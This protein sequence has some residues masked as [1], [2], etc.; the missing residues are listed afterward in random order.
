[1]PKKKTWN[2]GWPCVNVISVADHPLYAKKPLLW[3]KMK[4]K[5][6]WPLNAMHR[7]KF[8]HRGAFTISKLLQTSIYLFWLYLLIFCC[9]CLYINIKTDN[10]PL[11]HLQLVF[12][13]PSVNYRCVTMHFNEHNT[14]LTIPFWKIVVLFD[15]FGLFLWKGNVLSFSVSQMKKTISLK[16][17]LQNKMRG[18]IQ[19]GPLF[20]TKESETVQE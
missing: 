20:Q 10:M 5:I 6:I 9:F 7:I 3:A 2:G 17:R 1:M 19:S 14:R 8:E 11:L 16:H 4:N 18:T 13:D 15:H 12:V